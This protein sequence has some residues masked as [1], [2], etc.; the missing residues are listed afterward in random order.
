[1]LLAEQFIDAD[2][3]ALKSY[4]IKEGAFNEKREAVKEMLSDGV[5][6]N[7][8]HKYLK[9]PI[10]TITELQKEFNRENSD[11]GDDVEP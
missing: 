7:K 6:V 3:D 11:K 8:I 10:E 4:E 1:M 5:S 9:L 2:L